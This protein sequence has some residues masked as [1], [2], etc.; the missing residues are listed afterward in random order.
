M[1]I[2]SNRSEMLENEWYHV[3]YS[4]EIPEIALHSSIYHLT[5]DPEGPGVALSKENL[6]YLKS[7]AQQRYL[8]IILRDITPE[9]RETTM[10]RGILRS[11]SNYRRFKRFCIRHD[12]DFTVVNDQVGESLLHFL[13]CEIENVERG[14]WQ[15]C[16]NCTYEDIV[17]FTTE[18]HVSLDELGERLRPLCLTF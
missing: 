6:I 16:I 4:G 13:R 5:E 7:A 14:V 9:N 8:E 12:M 17:A 10:Y 1:E 3:R 18:L 15:S 2:K 11:I